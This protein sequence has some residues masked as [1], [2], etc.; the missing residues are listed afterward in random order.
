MTT[1]TIAHPR[2]AS[3]DEWLAERRE[4]QMHEKDLIK[5]RD[6]VSARRWRP[7]MVK[8]EKDY[9]FES[10]RKIGPEGKIVREISSSRKL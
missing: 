5:Q 9:V 8:I 7:P 3:Q 1:S 2:I 4:L 6:R 10:T